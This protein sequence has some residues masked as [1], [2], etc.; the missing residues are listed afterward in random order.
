M[1]SC[2]GQQYELRDYNASNNNT[3]NRKMHI[4]FLL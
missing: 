3:D 2:L 1:L 4:S